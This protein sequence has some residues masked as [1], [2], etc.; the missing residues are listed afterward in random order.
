MSNA[1]ERLDE[2]R[3]ETN[4]DNYSE[5]GAQDCGGAVLVDFGID[6]KG[7]TMLSAREI[8]AELAFAGRYVETMWATAA[9]EECP[10]LAQFIR[11]HPEGDFV[12]LTGA[13]HA[14]H[15]MALRDGVLTDTDLTSGNRRRINLAYRVH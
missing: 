11:N 7:K 15:T 6:P 2:I 8:K 5:K 12:L 10:T 13:N 3:A 9:T 14:P 4:L 1:A